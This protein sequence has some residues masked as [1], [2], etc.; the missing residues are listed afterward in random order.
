MSVTA[1]FP[2]CILV[3]AL[4]AGCASLTRPWEAPEV[5]LAGLRVEELGLARQTFVVTLAVRNP[6]DRALPIEGLTY[7]LSLEGVELAEGS[8][9]LEQRIPAFGE[10]MVDVEVVSSL[11]GVAGQLPA[12]ALKDRPLEWKVAGTATLAGGLVRLPYRYSG[13]VDPAR[14][15]SGAVQ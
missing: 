7:R 6:N 1:R 5:A 8:S 3:A 10:A 15:I 9:A 4:L 11:L 2:I 12:M 13:E 14:L